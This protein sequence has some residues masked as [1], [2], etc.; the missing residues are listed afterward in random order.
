ML[1]HFKTKL[2]KI[3]EVL[4][5]SV[6]KKDVTKDL[7]S[8]LL[9]NFLRLIAKNPKNQKIL[10]FLSQKE[11]TT[12]ENFR[13]ALEEAKEKFKDERSSIDFDALFVQA[14]NETLGAYVEELKKNL[15]PEKIGQITSVV[16]S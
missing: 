13:E 11:I 7:L 9:A 2:E 14:Q 3:F 5:S 6:N 4:G 16:K 12:P 8:A 10:S 15:S 1:D